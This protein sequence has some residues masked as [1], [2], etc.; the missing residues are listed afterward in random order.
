[1]SESERPGDLIELLRHRRRL[2]RTRCSCRRPLPC[3]RRRWWNHWWHYEVIDIEACI[4]QERRQ[5]YS[6]KRARE[7]LNGKEDA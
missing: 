4:R 2:I 1:M 3:P 5:H 7:M 6:F